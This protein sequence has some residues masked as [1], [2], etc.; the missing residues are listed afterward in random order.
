MNDRTPRWAR[1]A[2]AGAAIVVL[3][4]AGLRQIEYAAAAP[5]ERGRDSFFHLPRAARIA[6][7]DLR[8]DRVLSFYDPSALRD[9]T[10]KWPPLGEAV[11]AAFMLRRG[12]DPWAAY[13]ASQVAWI[14]LL[15]ASLY[16][17]GRRLGGSPA[18]GFVAALLG[19]LTLP[20]LALAREHNVEYATVASVGFALYGLV[21]ARDLTSS[22]GSAVLGFALGVAALTRPIA[23]ACVAPVV[24]AAFFLPESGTIDARRR[25]ANLLLALGV[26]ALVCGPLYLPRLGA[27]WRDGAYV[28]RDLPVVWRRNLADFPRY[29]ALEM[30]SPAAWA[31]TAAAAITALRRRDRFVAALIAG[32]G[33]SFVYLLTLA[34]SET[35]TAYYAPYAVFAALVVARGMKAWGRAARVAVAVL[36]TLLVA[37]PLVFPEAVARYAAGWPPRPWARA[38]FSRSWNHDRLVARLDAPDDVASR[39]WAVRS[40]FADRYATF[41]AD[42]VGILAD[43]RD[44]HGDIQ[45]G[46]AVART[47]DLGRWNVPISAAPA[48]FAA[49]DPVGERGGLGL[50]AAKP[51]VVA[52]WEREPGTPRDEEPAS[53]RYGLAVVRWTHRADLVVDLE[54]ESGWRDHWR[55]MHYVFFVRTDRPR[56]PAGDVRTP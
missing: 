23:A 49:H 2:A 16:G 50:V 39:A 53:L 48:M 44:L 46:M 27:L 13:A 3:A 36:A 52:V 32:G 8:P 19:A 56:D 45:S 7:A 6:A 38:A 22:G 10:M 11:A 40:L 34:Y 33:A 37:P 54:A 51:L 5:A 4:W 41:G 28:S 35:N 31:I 47:R 24:A 20:L 21:V 1:L 9:A 42:D 26:A 18:A 25:G 12:A 14:V 55:A 43:F 29:M 30:L 15:A 17:A